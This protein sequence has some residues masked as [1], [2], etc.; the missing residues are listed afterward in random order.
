MEV[1]CKLEELIEKTNLAEISM[2]L[3]LR[4]SVWKTSDK[5]SK[6]IS[7]GLETVRRQSLKGEAV[8]IVNTSELM[9]FR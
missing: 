5:K 3:G 7:K 2:D 6:E 4:R 9:D 1:E 8:S